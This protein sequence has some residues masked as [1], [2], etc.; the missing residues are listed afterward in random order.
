MGL[1]GLIVLVASCGPT[2]TPAIICGEATL[3]V[4]KTADT[5]DGSCDGADCSLREAVIKSNACPGT[6][7]V[8]VPAGTYN[9]TLAGAG[10]DL[11]ATGDLDITDGV[12]IMGDLQPVIDG[13]GRDR[14]FEV[15]P[16]VTAS[17]SYLVIQNGQ[18]QE[19][20]G[21]LN[22]GT[23]NVNEST[24][25]NNAA[26][27]P[28]GAAGTAN[29]G[30]IKSEGGGSLGV[31]LSTVSGNTAELGGGIMVS[32]DGAAS[33]SVMIS[34][35]MLADNS[36]S[37]SGGGF[38]FD[39]GVQAT[40]IRFQVERNSSGDH[41]NGIYNAG[42]LELTGGTITE[43]SG[44]M[45]G[46]GIYNDATGTAI[47][48]EVLV[49][50]NLTR[51]GGGIY[52]LGMAHFYYSALAGNQAERGEGGGA[53]NS[54]AGAG[55]LLN[56]TTVSGN[57]APLGGG[58]IRNVNGNLSLMFA[59]IAANDSGGIRSTAGGDRTM[60]NTIVAMNTGGNCVDSP[61]DSIGH[62]IEETDT[63]LFDEPTDLPNTDPQI[64]P[65]ALNGGLTPTHALSA[66]SPAI[67]SADPDRCSGTDQRLVVRPQGAGCDRGASEKEEAGSA[68]IHGLVFH[69]M[70]ALPDGPLP[71][72][73]PPGC[74]PE[75]DAY[76]GNGVLDPGEPG[77]PGV[78]V[79]L[80]AGTC[81]SGS[82]VST[83]VTAGDGTYSFA[84][85][86]A[87]TAFRSTR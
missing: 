23:L 7:T 84:G 82:P 16:G 28:D 59:T 44:G 52:N 83:A 55:L 54:G 65:L 50:N 69:D 79:Q 18:A 3:T 30:G 25:H 41:G 37:T 11:A 74:I 14:V 4:T 87:H 35:T 43:N 53:Y 34:H 38:W 31:Y 80:S 68:S 85:L 63:C 24:V 72:T 66:G 76:G 40:V 49:Q 32:A 33:P 8:T 71:P 47:S 29:G 62:N 2:G 5:N 45:Y 27:R 70:C 64:L 56:N 10:E 42:T 81:A 78:T 39:Q 48:R 75:G 60:R 46:G 6:Q 19:G 86:S 57:S 67:D 61:P 9:L 51:F 21:I 77:I 20:G 73:P 26:V 15:F 13:G 1:L 17:L 36:A 12:I 58:G 22:H